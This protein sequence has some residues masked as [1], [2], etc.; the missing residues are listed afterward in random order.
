M[1]VI[2]TVGRVDS[3]Y[4]RTLRCVPHATTVGL[5]CRSLM[6]L[7]SYSHHHPR[8]PRI[9]TTSVVRWSSRFVV[10]VGCVVMAQQLPM[11]SEFAS[12]ASSN[13]DGLHHQHA[14]AASTPPQPPMP[15][16]ERPQVYGGGRQ[17][18]KPYQE[19]SFFSWCSPTNRVI[20]G[21]IFGP[22]HTRCDTTCKSLM[23]MT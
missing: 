20:V 19:D 2:A 12:H 7:Q 13:L 9:G 17:G 18:A 14:A 10:V 21:G 6:P 4:G 11:S 23:S 16:F 15:I 5:V 8:V 22:P 3:Q 1:M